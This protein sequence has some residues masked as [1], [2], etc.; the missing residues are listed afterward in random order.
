MKKFISLLLALAM[1]FSLA[2][3]S[4]GNTAESSAPEQST[5]PS[6]EA[7]ANTEDLTWGLTPFAEPQTLRIGFFTGSPLSYPFLFADKLGVFKALNINVEYTCF[8]GGPAM[9]E[10]NAEWDIA[11]CGLGGLANGLYGYDFSLVDITDFEE[12]IAIFVRP[13][14]ELA[15][16]PTNPELW[17]GASCVYP[18]GTT[19]QA[20]LA[21]YLN[22]IGLTLADVESVN[23]DNSNA[24]TAFNGGTGDVLC[25]WNAIALSAEDA[26]FTRVG[27]SGTLG[28]TAPCGTFAKQDVMQDNFDLVVTACT[29]F[30][31]A[32]EWLYASDENKAQATQWYLEHCDEEGFLC[33]EDIA[34]RTIDW[35]RGPTT[36]EWIELFTK[37]SPDDAGLYTK[38][39]LLEAEKDILVGIDFFIGEGKYTNDDRTRYL[40]DQRID[41]SVALAAKE[42]LGK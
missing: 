8:T 15:K 17:K 18:A 22:K 3:C 31:K 37:T 38:R 42:M 14:S 21:A 40:D 30:H 5:A 10:A 24:L 27:D 11:S 35:Y 36:D 29:V 12:N 28:F 1:V 20:V 2:A 16:D 6:G 4:G 9:M 13:D 33:T 25:C 41:P 32:V 23:M 26:G 34:K 39:D 7:S 19:G